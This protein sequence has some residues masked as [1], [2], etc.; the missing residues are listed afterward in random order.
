MRN[1]CDTT[2]NMRAGGERKEFSS[3]LLSDYPMQSVKIITNNHDDDILA[4]DRS[5]LCHYYFH[6]QGVLSF[7]C[8][9]TL[10]VFSDSTPAV[11]KGFFVSP[12]SRH[13][14]EKVRRSEGQKARRLEGWEVG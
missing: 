10:S 13:F 14:W 5:C 11:F 9:Q 1:K 2:K 3:A 12:V 6:I 8:F 7:S 4:Y